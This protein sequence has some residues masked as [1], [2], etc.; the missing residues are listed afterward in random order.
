MSHYQILGIPETATDAEIKKAYRKLALQYHPD[1]NEGNREAEETFKKVA[2]AY[3]T[4]SDPGKRKKY[5]N[6]RRAESSSFSFDAFVNNNFKSDEFKSYRA[7]SSARARATQGKQHAPPPSTDHLDIRLKITV[8]LADALMGKKIELEFTRKKIE[9][10]GKTD[11]LLNYTQVDEEKEIT[12]QINLKQ[13][14][15][16]LKREENGYSTRVRVGKIGNEEVQRRTNIWG[17]LE[18]IPLF[19]DLYVDIEFEVPSGVEIVGN[20]IVHRVEIPLYKVL[21]KG[22]KI[23]IATILN[24]KY[25]AEIN[26]PKNLTDLRFILDSEGVL[27]DKKELGKYII[28]FDIIT[29]DLTKLTKEEK[30]SFKAL[31]QKA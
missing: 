16:S 21:I 2:D 7:Q 26:Q 3:S 14:H 9:V 15:L 31:L 20:D 11:T 6:S 5:D 24:K 23:R 28:C 12:I 8:A 17:D 29:P 30:D 1:K 4:L 13:M 27:N 19:G 22:E 10:V 25:D 18:Q